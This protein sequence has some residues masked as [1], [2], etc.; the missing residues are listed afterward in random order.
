M[1]PVSLPAVGAQARRRADGML[2]EVYATD[3]PHDLLSVRW[4]TVPGAYGHEDCTPDQFARAWELT[5]I[6]IEPPRETHVA[7]ALI[8]LIVLLVFCSL[9]VHDARSFYAGYDPFKPITA[10]SPNTLNSATALHEKFGILAAT[11][12]SDGADDY[13]R[14]ISEHRFHWNDTDD[15]APRFDRFDPT[16]HAPGV[17]TL[18]TNKPNISNGFGVFTPITVY[19]NYDTQSSEVL[20]YSTDDPNS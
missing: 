5:G 19:C 7:L 15:L 18:I 20:S 10:E 12:C 17:L 9:L 6:Q 8:A 16:V 1:G 4:A 13:I 2:G 14:S 3:P 11:A